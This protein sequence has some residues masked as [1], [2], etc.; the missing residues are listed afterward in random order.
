MSHQGSQPTRVV[1][2]SAVVE[3]L[4]GIGPHAAWAAGQLAD[5]HLIAPNHMLVE[6]A[7]AL[8]RVQARGWVSSEMAALAHADLLELPVDLYPYEAVAE[9]AWDLRATVASYDACYVALAEVLD[10]DLVTLDARLA[11]APGSTCRFRTPPT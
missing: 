4:L 11:R 7:N 1:D 9:R 8:R 10:A 5:A 6:A 3:A 2:A